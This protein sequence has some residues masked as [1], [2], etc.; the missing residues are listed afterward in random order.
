MQPIRIDNNPTQK[1]K[2]DLENFLKELVPLCNKHRV[3][4]VLRSTG[5]LNTEP[6]QGILLDVA[7][8]Y[9]DEKSTNVLPYYVDT[10]SGDKP[11]E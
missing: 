6:V 5:Y 8:F 2:D 11:K 9:Y 3:W 1:V 4:V 10:L 7:G